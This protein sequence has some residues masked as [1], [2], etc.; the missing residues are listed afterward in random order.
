MRRLKNYIRSTMLTERMSGLA[1]LHAYRHMEI[2]I[3]N[4]HLQVRLAVKCRLVEINERK[5][6]H[7]H[8]HA[9]INGFSLVRKALLRPQ[10]AHNCTIYFKIFRGEG[11]CPLTPRLF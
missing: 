2:D 3:D 8:F 4:Y 11:A 10:N 6:I 9:K 1:L 5:A 7:L